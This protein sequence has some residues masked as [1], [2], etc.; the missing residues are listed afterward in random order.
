M[1]DDLI[2]PLLLLEAGLALAGAMYFRK[3]L[4][5]GAVVLGV[6]FA[7][8]LYPPAIHLSG[9]IYEP[10]LSFWEIFSPYSFEKYSLLSGFFL[11]VPIALFLILLLLSFLVRATRYVRIPCIVC[12]A[13]CSSSLAG[14]FFV[15]CIQGAT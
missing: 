11:D 9:I 10:V 15:W 12:I 5:W 8:F 7:I 1:S 14:A 13:F 2:V 6:A 3:D 4:Q